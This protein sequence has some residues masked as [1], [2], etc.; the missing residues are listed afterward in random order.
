MSTLDNQKNTTALPPPETTNYTDSGSLSF[1]RL[2]CNK[3]DL[4]PTRRGGRETKKKK[5][6]RTFFAGVVT[7]EQ[8]SDKKWAQK[9]K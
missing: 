7:T 9:E 5:K 8:R 4:S 2:A 3:H 6:R 1:A